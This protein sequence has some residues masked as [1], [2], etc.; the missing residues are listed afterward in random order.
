M[1][2]HA[3]KSQ[4]PSTNAQQHG[5]DVHKLLEQNWSHRI[6]PNYRNQS[7]IICGTWLSNRVGKILSIGNY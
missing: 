2:R 5:N 3:I 6:L 7:A 1:E 4:A